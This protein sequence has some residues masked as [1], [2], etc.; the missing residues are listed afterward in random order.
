MINFLKVAVFSLLMVFGFWA[1][2]NFYIPQIKPAPPPVEEK[3][4]LGAMTMDQFIAL[5]G[6]IFNGKGTCTLCHNKMGRAP[7]LS[8]LGKN[9]PLRLKDPRYKGTAKTPEEYLQES[10][11]K[12]SAYVV[13]GF[14]KSGTND[15]ESP[16][17][18]VTGG[19][20]GLSQAEL[21]A[22]QAYL[23][24]LNSLE[25]TVEIPKMAPP[26][27]EGAAK[28]EEAPLT[29]PQAVIAK[30][31]CGACHTVADQSGTIGPNLTKIG[32]TKNKDYIRQSIL[33][34]DAVIAKGYPAGMMP[35]TFGEQMKAKELEMLVDYL[36]GSKK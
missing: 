22:V 29:T 33:D 1:F 28:A 14:G 30:Y 36:A 26:A 18:D 17:P 2:A 31:G 21:K 13:A 24:D 10:M 34:P 4:D 11:T 20:I 35:K 12:P 8:E 27:A 32:A 19:G 15:T 23:L 16:M 9:I 5:G 7:M 25:V 6:K 3:L